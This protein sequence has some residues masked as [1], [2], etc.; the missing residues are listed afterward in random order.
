MER[1]LVETSGWWAEQ[2]PFIYGQPGGLDTTCTPHRPASHQQS[3]EEQFLRTSCDHAEGQTLAH[4]TK[5]RPVIWV[6]LY[7]LL[8]ASKH[9]PQ[10]GAERETALQLSDWTS[11]RRYQLQS[12]DILSHYDFS[13]DWIIN[14]QIDFS[15]IINRKQRRGENPH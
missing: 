10:T 12:S 9:V 7:T 15:I 2:C 6:I 11:A 3:A 13:G 4:Q 14:S 1:L 8:S 5:N